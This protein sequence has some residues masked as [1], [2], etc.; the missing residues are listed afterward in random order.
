MA[1]Q[2]VDSDSATDRLTRAQRA[3]L[4]QDWLIA[5][6]ASTLRIAPDE[7][8]VQ[9]P[10]SE[11]GLGSYQG[12]RPAG[13]LEEWLGRDLPETLVWDYPTVADVTQY[14][15]ESPLPPRL[16]NLHGRA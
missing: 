6:L 12:V 4:I 15:S 16:V 14:L 11:Y 3:Q 10:F 9:V 13:D 1:Q 2:T 5:K 8:D 7:I